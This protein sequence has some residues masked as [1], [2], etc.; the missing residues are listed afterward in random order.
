MTLEHILGLATGVC[1]GVLLQ[2]GGVVR[3]EKQV[4]MLLGKD[5]T[6]LRFMLTAIV[7]GMTGVLLLAHAGVLTLNHKPMNVGGVV[8]GAALFGAGWGVAGLCPGTTLGAIGEGR[9]HALFTMAG[10]LAG[11]MFYAHTYDF[12]KRTV[13]AWKDYGKIGLP[14]TLDVPTAVFVAAFAVGAFFLFRFFDKKNM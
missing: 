14:E 8:L 1:F 9:L 7:V 2:R 10:M 6:V 3:F 5:M 13:L 4:G 11:A 12:M